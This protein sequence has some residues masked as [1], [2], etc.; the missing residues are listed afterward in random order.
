MSLPRP[1]NSGGHTTLH[2]PE[3]TDA[4]WVENMG[5]GKVT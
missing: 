3:I 5:R 2:R 1:K 4:H